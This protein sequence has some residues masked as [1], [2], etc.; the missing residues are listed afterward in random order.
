MPYTAQQR[1]PYVCAYREPKGPLVVSRPS[2]YGRL[3]KKGLKENLTVTPPYRKLPSKKLVYTDGFLALL[4]E[5]ACV[6]CT[7]GV[8]A[9]TVMLKC[10]LNMVEWQANAIIRTGSSNKKKH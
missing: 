1:T 10:M 6:I 9:R 4:S 8:Y 2:G 3:K 5:L 7:I